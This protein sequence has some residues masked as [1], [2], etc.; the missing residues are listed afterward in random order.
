M[1]VEL[2]AVTIAPSLSSVGMWSQQKVGHRLHDC[3]QR[4]FFLKKRAMNGQFSESGIKIVETES[5]GYLVLNVVY[6]TEL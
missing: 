6:S 5:A 4:I 2:T 1:Y 3:Q